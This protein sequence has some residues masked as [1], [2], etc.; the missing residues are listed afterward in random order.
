MPNIIVGFISDLALLLIMLVGL[1][2][3]RNDGGGTFGIGLFLWKQVGW[4]T[5]PLVVLLSVR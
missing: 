5:L 4:R 3:M 2:R 1:I